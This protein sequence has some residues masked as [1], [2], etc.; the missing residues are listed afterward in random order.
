LAAERICF[1]GR[2]LA[3][4]HWRGNDVTDYSHERAR[5]SIPQC[6]RAT[7]SIT[8]DGKHLMLKGKGS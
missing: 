3:D 5:P 6:K 7:A 4:A 2:F 8:F 1:V